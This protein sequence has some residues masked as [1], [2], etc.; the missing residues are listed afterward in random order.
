M[1]AKKPAPTDLTSTCLKDNLAKGLALTSKA[2]ANRSTLPIL[3]YILLRAEADSRI[4]LTGTN[5]EMSLTAYIGAEHTGEWAVAVPT[6]PMLD[7]VNALPEDEVTLDYNP[8]I[9]SLTIKSGAFVNTLKCL[10]A[11]EFPLIPTVQDGFEMNAADLKAAINR[12]IF[13]AAT[14]ESRP[15][16]TGL[17]WTS[18]GQ[19]LTLN[20]ADGFRLGTTFL[21]ASLPTF[22]AIVPSKAC[23]GQ[24]LQSILTEDVVQVAVL[25]EKNQIGF[26]CGPYEMVMQLIEG[27][28]PDLTAVVPKSYATSLNVNVALLAQ[29][30][31]AANIFA[32]ESAKTLRFTINPENAD[33]ELYAVGAEL[34][35]HTSHLAIAGDGPSLTIACNVGYVVD[36]LKAID[37]PQV[38]LQFNNPTSPI[39]IT[40]DGLD[41]YECVVMPMHIGK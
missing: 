6:K 30:T 11:E 22:S 4:K 28:F 10:D 19:T 37:T 31:R 2:V 12:V 5:L 25:S 34:G 33:L 39:R 14:D 20:G 15:V 35:E 40:P 18:D 24:H 8:K 41:N 26:R 36:V 21:P 17:L 3:G 29:A 1:P 7:L 16:L 32:R 27:V 13:C 9:Q 23:D 38:R